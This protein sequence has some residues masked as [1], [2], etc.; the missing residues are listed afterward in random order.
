MRA[1]FAASLWAVSAWSPAEAAIV[2]ATS[3]AVEAPLY[4]SRLSDA[5]GC[6]PAGCVGELT[7]VRCWSRETDMTWLSDVGVVCRW[8]EPMRERI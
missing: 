8:R 2:G 6:D 1:L 3:V 4:D 7:R 5:G